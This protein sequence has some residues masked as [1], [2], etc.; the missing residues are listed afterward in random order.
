LTVVVVD[1]A[2]RIDARVSDNLSALLEQ[3][4][5]RSREVVLVLTKA[6]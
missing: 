5:R 3:A 1:G 6:S 4:L 2:K